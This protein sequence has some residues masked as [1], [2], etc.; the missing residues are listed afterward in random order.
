MEQIFISYDHQDH[1]W[2]THELLPKISDSGLKYRHDSQIH[3]GTSIYDWIDSSRNECKAFILVIS[4][5]YVKNRSYA[6]A[7]MKELIIR[8]ISGR[9]ILVPI[10]K[11]S[12][13]ENDL[14]FGLISLNSIKNINS[15]DSRIAELASQLKSENTISKGDAQQLNNYFVPP[16]RRIRIQA[17]THCTQK[18]PWCHWDDF[19]KKIEAPNY[20]LVLEL[21]KKLKEARD[22]DTITYPRPNISFTLTGGE[23]LSKEDKDKNGVNWEAFASI[24]PE[25]TYLL[26]NGFLLDEYAIDFISSNSLKG[27]R[28]DLPLIPKSSKYRGIQPDPKYGDNEKYFEIVLDNIHNLLKKTNTKVRFNY[29]VTNDNVSKVEDYLDFIDKQ[30]GQY[31]SKIEGVAFIEHYPRLKSDSKI[32]NIADQWAEENKLQLKKDPLVQRKKTAILHNGMRVEF[33]K[34]NC[35]V[36]GD[37]ISRCF[38]CVQ[39]QDIAISADG[40]IRICS[41]WDT[42]KIAGCRYIFTHFETSQPLIGIS[43]AIRRRYGIVGFYNHFG[44]IS[45]ILSRKKYPEFLSDEDHKFNFKSFQEFATTCCIDIS[46]D[47]EKNYDFIS[48]IARNILS[49]NSRFNKLFEE[50]TFDGKDL[51]NSTR[52][53]VF[54]IKASYCISIALINGNI[55]T[56]KIS[57]LQ[58]R[59]NGLL[60]ILEYLCVDENLFS[61]GR[62][63]M[64]KG[65]STDLLKIIA[66]K[67]DDLINDFLSD[68]S[69]FLSTVAFENCKADVVLD[70]L[71]QQVP[72]YFIEKVPWVQYL[73]GCLHRQSERGDDAITALELAYSLSDKMITSGNQ[74]YVWLLREVRSEAKRSLGAIRKSIPEKAEQAEIDFS[75]AN[76]LSSIDNTSLRFAALFS[77][78]YSSMLKYFQTY[79]KN[80]LSKEA[81]KAHRDFNESITLNPTFYAS[82][83]RMGLLELT[84]GQSTTACK[85]LEQAKR[86]F[87][88]RGLLTDQEYLNSILCNLIYVVAE[89]NPS[90]YIQLSPV[91]SLGIEECK[92]AGKKDVAC[93][94]EN[95]EFLLK[96]IKKRPRF[97]N[98]VVTEVKDFIS[99]CK[100]LYNKLQ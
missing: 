21:M 69:Y 60:C 77:D 57:V 12:V 65:L 10:F 62:T 81:Y 89:N 31:K 56:G 40:R 2:V 11:E 100:K 42:K 4:N 18:C 32:F 46:D 23:P 78:G 52:L 5:N 54:L 53:C 29:V 95:A 45:N 49:E 82:R 75:E 51:E 14:P 58:A 84:L 96:F 80:I 15:L 1:D 28:I 63:L 20:S 13:D 33:T 85:H 55:G 34:L 43:G 27:I 35:A 94:K 30:F 97:N 38:V 50:S 8:S 3:L 68:S 36:T 61:T 86:S 48:L 17:S 66:E 37:L 98:R 24:D 73:I 79:G 76:F 70:F 16:E 9:I 47:C 74:K 44:I 71:K 99:R 64:A 92:N 7:E 22:S 6:H 83:I 39:E 26:T 41:G 67:K 72:E 88:K 25:N 91:W 87:S 19:P 93:V 90:L 59:L